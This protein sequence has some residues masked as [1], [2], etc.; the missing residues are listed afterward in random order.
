LP[1]FQ[2]PEQFSK[3][4]TFEKGEDI[5]H[6]LAMEAIVM[7]AHSVGTVPESD[8]FPFVFDKV[9]GPFVILK[10]RKASKCRLCNRV[11]HHQNPYLLIV[12]DTK[13][14]FFHCRRAPPDKK[15][16]IGCLKSEEEVTVIKSL[17]VV[18]GNVNTIIEDKKTEIVKNVWTESK[19]QKLKE[20]AS[21]ENP[22]S[23]SSQKKTLDPNCSS[24][25][26]KNIADG[27]KKN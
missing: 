25:I 26:M 7:L 6:D 27:I 14:V 2:I 11:H 15:L 5:E 8:N 24:L 20:L 23:K 21:S 17:E 19:I 16:Y 9:D 13:N 12:P 18:T 3:T 4:K 10:R 22:L 1:S